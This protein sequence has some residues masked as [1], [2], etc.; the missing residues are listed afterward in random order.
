[1]SR[2]VLTCSPTRAHSLSVS[3]SFKDVWRNWCQFIPSCI[4]PL[5][6]LIVVIILNQ[7]VNYFLPKKKKQLYLF[8]KFILTCMF[9]SSENSWDTFNEKIS[10]IFKVVRLTW[11]CAVFLGKKKIAR[12]QFQ[13][14]KVSEKQIDIMCLSIVKNKCYLDWY[15]VNKNH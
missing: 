14:W 5:I 3:V 6:V 2:F 4:T 10:W 1:M 11:W 7:D 12:A 8:L 15:I 9:F 13:V